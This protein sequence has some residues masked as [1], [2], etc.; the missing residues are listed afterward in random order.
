MKE[1]TFESQAARIENFYHGFTATHLIH[2]GDKLGIFEVLNDNK[3]GL[4]S[5]EL[6]SKLGLHEP[7]LKI[8]CQTALYLEILD[9]DE[10]GKF[11][12]Q[13][14]MNE[15]LGDKA[16][17]RNMLGRFNSLVNVTG[18]RFKESIVHY[19]TGKTLEGYN[20][21]HSEIVAEATKS[22]HTY[23]NVYFKQLPNTHP[24]KQMLE[25]GI[26]FLDI[27]CGNGRLI[28]QLAA[29]FTNSRF[30][31][32]EPSLYGI[33]DA[34]KNI[35]QLGLKDRVFVK[36]LS[37]EELQYKEEFEIACMTLVF[38]EINPK[39]RFKALE[40]IYNALKKGGRLIIFDFSY[41]E[42]LAD[43]KNPNYGSVII[44][45]FNETSLGAVF[46]TLTEQNEMFT[47]VG[48]TEIQRMRLKGID[49]ITVLK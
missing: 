9:Y 35:D 42:H 26:N 23:L 36:N 17:F 10:G 21:Q 45:Q 15:I 19:K 22:F 40:N 24:I 33:N 46:L 8:W 30:T 37:G 43:F 18:E 27:G 5:S 6:A 20:P 1:I 47:I 29:L 38:H 13:P 14:F 25:K 16:N 31:G 4:T 11:K 3:K 39:I 49:I 2:I 48:F 34:T 7:Y 44:H 28:I 32:V 12:F 41:P